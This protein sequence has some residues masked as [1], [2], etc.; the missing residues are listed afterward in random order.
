MFRS[1]AGMDFTLTA[2]FTNLATCR[3]ARLIRRLFPSTEA[4]IMH[5]R[6]DFTRWSNT[7]RRRAT[8]WWRSS[9]GEVQDTAAVFSSLPGAVRR[10]SQAGVHALQPGSYAR[11]RIAAARFE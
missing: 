4:E 7:F 11:F 10:R 5:T 8:S 9:I 6:T 2:I 3:R 1:S